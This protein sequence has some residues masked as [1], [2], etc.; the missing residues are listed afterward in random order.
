EAARAA[1][2]A[3]GQRLGSCEI[4]GL[5]ATESLEWCGLRLVRFQQ[6]LAGIPVFGAEVVVGVDESGRTRLILSD[7]NPAAWSLLRGPLRRDVAVGEALDVALLDLGAS[8]EELTG[9]L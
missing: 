6:G 4:A 3:H 8:P 9:A 2:I 5:W 7:W 1:L